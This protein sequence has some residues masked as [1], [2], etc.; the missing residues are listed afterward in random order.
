MQVNVTRVDVFSTTLL[1]NILDWQN[2][3]VA[4]SG[5]NGFTNPFT[6]LFCEFRTC[7]VRSYELLTNST[8]S[9]VV[10]HNCGLINALKTNLLYVY[11]ST[12]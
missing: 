9:C 4:F 12:Q 8:F 7:I 10:H 3:Q 1:M 6:T 11:I 2:L 5:I